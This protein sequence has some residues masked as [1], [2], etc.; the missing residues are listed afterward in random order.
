MTDIEYRKHEKEEME[1][2]IEKLAEVLT[3]LTRDHNDVNEGYM[4]WINKT[5]E[6]RK[7]RKELYPQIR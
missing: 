7:A 1:E 6:A 4:I 5:L 3:N 2:I